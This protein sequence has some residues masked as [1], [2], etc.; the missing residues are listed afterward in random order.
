MMVEYLS[1]ALVVSTECSVFG[2]GLF[3]LENQ[4]FG[5]GFLVLALTLKVNSFGPIA[6]VLRVHMLAHVP[7][8]MTHGTGTSF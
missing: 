8:L 5:L 4:V 6:L 3:G 2:C 1:L 7:S